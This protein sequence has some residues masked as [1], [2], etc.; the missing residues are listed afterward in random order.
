MTKITENKL[1]LDS[2]E[3]RIIWVNRLIDKLSPEIDVF[4]IQVYREELEDLDEL[5]DKYMKKVK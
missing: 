3:T 2:L 1:I 4:V 5:R